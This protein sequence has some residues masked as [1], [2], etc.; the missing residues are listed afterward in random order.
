MAGATA[1]INVRLDGALK[2][3]GD[4]ALAEE[5]IAVTQIV[6]A[7]WRKLAERGRAMDEIKRL[8]L[9]EGRDAQELATPNPVVRGWAL[10]DEFCLSV[11]YDPSDSTVKAQSWDE[12]YAEAMNERYAQKGLFL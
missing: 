10:A 12:L 3:A 8:L 4:A 7:L 6:R 11:G 1:T 5:G 9:D 2:E